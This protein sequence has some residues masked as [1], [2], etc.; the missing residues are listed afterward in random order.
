M[1]VYL[2]EAFAEFRIQNFLDWFGF[3]TPIAIVVV[4]RTES[5]LLH[6]S[7]RHS[8]NTLSCYRSLQS[9]AQRVF[10]H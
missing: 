7:T 10:F 3:G 5:N 8:F 4:I 1:A 2:V 6:W 9:V